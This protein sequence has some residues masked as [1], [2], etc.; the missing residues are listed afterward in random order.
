MANEGLD[1]LMAMLA[2]PEWRA[3]ARE[4]LARNPRGH[5]LLR[6]LMQEVDD[7]EEADDV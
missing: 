6:H 3:R 4:V 7:D 5:Y 1:E 2:D